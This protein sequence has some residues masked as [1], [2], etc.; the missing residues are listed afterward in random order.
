MTT[1]SLRFFLRA[2]TAQCHAELDRAIG[3]IENVAAYARYVQ[4][5]HAFRSSAEAY[6]SA[7]LPPAF[8]D[9]RATRLAG[10]LQLD[11]ADLRLPAIAPPRLDLPGG[12]S[13]LIGLLYVLEGSALGARLIIK[14]AAALGFTAT[15]GARHLA[16]QAAPD[17]GWKAFLTLLDQAPNIDRELAAQGAI[18]TFACAREAVGL[19]TPGLAQTPPEECLSGYPG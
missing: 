3:S 15:H 9:W 11:L 18:A 19:A 10:L 16:V 4:A 5:M 14:S 2:Q 17:S 12:T 7:D 1:D 8:A 13:S 6:S